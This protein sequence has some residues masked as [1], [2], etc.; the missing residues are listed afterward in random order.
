MV[1]VKEK[2]MISMTLNQNVKTP[3]YE[4]LYEF[5]KSEIRNGTYVYNTKLPSKRQLASHLQCSQNT[6]QT[7]YQQLIAEGYII[8]KPKS[9]FY[10]CRLDG[11]FLID[12]Q[13]I[14]PDKAGGKTAAYRYDFSHHGVDADSFP[15]AFWRRI[16]K[17]VINEYDRDLLKLGNAQGD[18]ALRQKIANY[19]HQ[20]RSVQCTP[21]QII[22]SSGTEFLIQ[23]LI[24][25]LPGNNIYA[26]EDP[27]YERLSLIFKSN[28]VRYRYVTLDEN[29][30]TLE[31]LNNSQSDVI[32]ITPS[33]QFPTGNIMPVTRRIQLLN[34]A[35]ENEGR[36]IIEDDY[37]SEFKYSGRPIPSLQG[38]DAG[39]KVIYIGAFSKSLA[40]SIRISYAVLPDKLLESY[41]KRL[42]FYICP[43]P[44]I[45]QQVLCRFMDDGH[46]ERHLNKMRNIYKK[47]REILVSAIRQHL[48]KVSIIGANAGLHLLIEVQNGMSEAE[49]IVS[50]REASVKVYGL[51]QY[52]SSGQYINHKPTILLGYATM[53]QIEIAE[54]AKLLQ[55]AWF[56]K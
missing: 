55:K 39:E 16:T 46:F 33:H 3:L 53:T 43:V 4:Q 18:Y 54:A 50:A 11:L 17:E 34:W 13:Q 41:R 49:L 25:L 44:A 36:Y 40:P 7:A 51:S 29:G 2:M 6:V 15:Y 48:P 37:D 10:V 19:L 47:K 30:M 35:N 23:I 52:C 31:G 28:R 32:C 8:A 56:S 20:S 12:N 42:S 14:H 5:I 21:E 22:I 38:L 26:L 45:E 24:Q 9:G 27:G 1:S